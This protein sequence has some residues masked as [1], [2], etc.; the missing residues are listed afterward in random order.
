MLTSKQKK[1]LKSLANTST[2]KYQ[3]GKGEVDKNVINLLN[4]A[5]KAHEL[6]KVYFNKSVA[7]TMDKLVADIIKG[8]N[9]EL[10]ATIGH[11]IIIYK[12]NPEKKNR[13]VLA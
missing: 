4:S 5:L 10:I 1:Q 2:H 9:A 3:I 12:A 6:I 7:P 13:I 8:T 11:M